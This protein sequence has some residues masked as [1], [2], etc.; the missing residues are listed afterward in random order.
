MV[1]E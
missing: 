1:F